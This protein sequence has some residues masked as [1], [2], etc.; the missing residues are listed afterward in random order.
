MPGKTSAEEMPRLDAFDQEF[1][2]EPVAILR[3]HRRRIRLRTWVLIF[4]VLGAGVISALAV[5]W[6]NGDGLL[7]FE[8]QS[9]A[10]LFQRSASRE[11]SDEQI[12]RLRLEVDALKKV[13]SDLTEAHRQ[14][15]ETIAA[16]QATAASQATE[17][18]PRAPVPGEFWH[19]NLAALNFGIAGQSQPPA[20]A[21]PPRRRPATARPGPRE[22][23]RRDNGGNGG[24]PLSLEAPAQ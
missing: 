24:T 7:R 11:D 5:S 8:L 13:I 9:A 6:P 18:E 20:A 12:D 21:P 16:L 3:G 14:A 4:V 15:G 2:R 17:Q 1:G 23:A 10:P 19:S 22:P